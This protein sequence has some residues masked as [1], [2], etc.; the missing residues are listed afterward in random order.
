MCSYTDGATESHECLSCFLTI[1]MIARSAEGWVGEGA[2]VS[3]GHPG[4]MRVSSPIRFIFEIVLRSL[5]RCGA[6]S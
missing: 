1:L 6:H 3:R 5:L 4:V 2:W